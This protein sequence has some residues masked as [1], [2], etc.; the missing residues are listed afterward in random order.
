MHNPVV[1]ENTAHQVVAF[2]P[3]DGDTIAAAL[4]VW[5]QHSRTAHNE[6]SVGT[7]HRA[8]GSLPC[9]WVGIWL[10]HQPWGRIHVLVSA[11]GT[12]DITGLVLDRAGVALGLAVL[13]QK[14]ADQLS[15]RAAS[16]VIADL[17][18]GRFGSTQELMRRARSLGSDL[19]GG[20]LAALIVEPTDLTMLADQ[21]ELT[22][23]VRQQFRMQLRAQLRSA[24]AK[25]HCT[26]L[27]GL[28]GDR[29]LAVVVTPGRRKVGEVLR[30]V[31]VSLRRRVADS[32][33]GLLLAVGAS[34]DVQ[35]DD[36]QR[37]FEQA[38][39]AVEFGRG[40]G[41]QDLYQFGNLGT[42][43][44]LLRLAEG[45]EL[46]TFV[47]SEIGTLLQHDAQHGAK[48][49][50]TL[51][52]YLTNAGRKSDTINALRIQRRTLYARLVRIERELGRSLDDQ[53]TR[54]RITLALQGLDILRERPVARRFQP[55]SAG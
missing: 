19:S 6:T 2:S 22:E 36:L 12:D 17:L 33:P 24:L 54:T 31:A 50:P 53:D 32:T 5:D 16:A 42:Y 1:L 21:G 38:S 4:A 49:M 18:S 29:V 11:Q 44:L 10:H 47:E 25:H 55:G 40:S 34:R 23:Q 13:S 45:P 20:H 43:P 26:S 27:V 7:V 52:S 8:A 35:A 9:A 28:E 48:L 51:R 46:A 14:D 30:E 37:A 3:Q 39:V 41:Q 15:D